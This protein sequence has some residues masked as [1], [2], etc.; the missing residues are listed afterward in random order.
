MIPSPITDMTEADAFAGFQ[1]ARE[2]FLR[3]PTDTNRA[4]VLINL[5]RYLHSVGVDVDTIRADA[6]KANAQMRSFM[7]GGPRPDLGV[8]QTVADLELQATERAAA[9]LGDRLAHFTRQALHP[10]RNEET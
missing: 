5:R 3:A 8:G 7:A 4:T 1:R 6:E 10:A 9:A 2:R